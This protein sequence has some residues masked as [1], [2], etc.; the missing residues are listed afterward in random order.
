MKAQRPEIVYVI[1]GVRDVDTILSI[2][3]ML[4]SIVWVS[5]V[6]ERQMGDFVVSYPENTLYLANSI[7]QKGDYKVTNF[8]PYTLVLDPRK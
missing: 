2:K 5:E 6:E 1:N 3:Q 7:N 8:S 4:Q